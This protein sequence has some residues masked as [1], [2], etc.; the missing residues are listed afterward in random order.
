MLFSRTKRPFRGAIAA[1]IF[2]LLALAIW[3]YCRQ[4]VEIP[5]PDAQRFAPLSPTTMV[6]DAGLHLGDGAISV[7]QKPNASAPIPI[8]PLGD[9]PSSINFAPGKSFLA[10]TEPLPKTASTPGA[11]QATGTLFI[12][13]HTKVRI[14]IDGREV[15]SAKTEYPLTAGQHEIVLTELTQGQKRRLLV[16]IQPNQT[17]RIEF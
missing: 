7:E 16:Q 8:I 1:G 12:A 9:V 13:S 15:S 3:A 6:A 4:Q 5:P 14:Q 10:Q 17:R 2:A 11:Q